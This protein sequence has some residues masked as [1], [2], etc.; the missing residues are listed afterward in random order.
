M[1]VGVTGLHG[2]AV[3]VTVAVTVAELRGAGVGI[4]GLKMLKMFLI[5][6]TRFCV[7]LRCNG[8]AKR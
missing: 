2:A 3:A 5:D 4:F 8:V 7:D 6:S 1:T